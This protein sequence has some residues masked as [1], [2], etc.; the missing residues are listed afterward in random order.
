MAYYGV[1]RPE[2]GFNL[3]YQGQFSGGKIE[4]KVPA[5][6]K[7][8]GEDDFLPVF[9]MGGTFR[10]CTDLRTAPEIPSS[11]IFMYETFRGCTSLTTAPA[12]PNSVTDMGGTFK[13]AT[14]HHYGSL[15]GSGGAVV[16]FK[17]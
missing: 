8:A 2:R 4:G 13:G 10:G 3:A 14:V 9:E 12:I 5:Y 6:I 11:V 1:E 15:Y 17:I 7:K 16:E